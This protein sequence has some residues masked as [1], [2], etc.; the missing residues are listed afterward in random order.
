MLLILLTDM[1]SLVIVMFHACRMRVST[2]FQANLL[3]SQVPMALLKTTLL[4]LALG[5]LQPW[6]GNVELSPYN[7]EGQKLVVGYVSQQIAAFNGGFPSTILKFVRSG[8]YVRGSWF[9]RLKAIDH[10]LTEQALRQVRDVGAADRKIGELSGGQKQAFISQER[11]L[12]SLICSSLMSR[13]QGWIK[14]AG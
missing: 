9:R 3:Q 14:R 13:R 5:L 6:K 12:S 11:W 2:Y 4:K 7:S 10:E 8:R 1:L